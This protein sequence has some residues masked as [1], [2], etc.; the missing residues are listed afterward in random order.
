MTL[1][2]RAASLVYCGHRVTTARA[3]QVAVY[4]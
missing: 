4:G 2:A 3:I 1:D